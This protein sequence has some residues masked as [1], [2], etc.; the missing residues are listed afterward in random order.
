[1]EVELCEWFPDDDCPASGANQCRNEATLSIGTNP[2]W[3]V[4]VNC[5]RLPN[6]KSLRLRKVRLLNRAKVGK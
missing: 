2:N 1:M 4:C 5:S 3:H 6:F